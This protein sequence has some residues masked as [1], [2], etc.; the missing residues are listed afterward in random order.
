METRH[1]AD[2]SVTGWGRLAVLVVQKHRIFPRQGEG[3]GAFLHDV[4][5]R[6][7]G[8]AN[9]LMAVRTVSVEDFLTV[10]R[11]VQ[12][13]GEPTYHLIGSLETLLNA[14]GSSGLIHFLR[15]KRDEWVLASPI[16]RPSFLSVTHKRVGAELLFA[17]AG[18]PNGRNPSNRPPKAHT[19]DRLWRAAPG[20][21][22]NERLV[23][24]NLHDIKKWID[25]LLDLPSDRDS[26]IPQ[27][28]Y[29]G[30]WSEGDRPT[31]DSGKI[32]AF[33]RRFDG[34][35]I[36]IIH[37]PESD[38]GIFIHPLQRRDGSWDLYFRPLNHFKK[39]YQARDQRYE[40]DFL[41][42]DENRF[43]SWALERILDDDLIM[44]GLVMP[45]RVNH[46]GCPDITQEEWARM[47]RDPTFRIEHRRV[48]DEYVKRGAYEERAA[49][50]PVLQD[51]LRLADGPRSV[52]VPVR[53]IFDR[54][55]E[56]F[57]SHLV[58]LMRLS[59]RCLQAPIPPSLK[60]ALTEVL[61]G[62][63][64]GVET[65]GDGSITLIPPETIPIFGDWEMRRLAGI[66]AEL[67]DVVEEPD[68]DE[69]FQGQGACFSL[70][71]VS[72]DAALLRKAGGEEALPYT[73]SL[74]RRDDR[75]DQGGRFRQGWLDS[76]SHA[77][78][79]PATQALVATLPNGDIVGGLL[80]RIFQDQKTG[81]LSLYYIPSLSHPLN[82]W[83]SEDFLGPAL[84]DWAREIAARLEMPLIEKDY[85]ITTNDWWIHPPDFPVS[86]PAGAE[87]AIARLE[88]AHRH[89]LHDLLPPGEGSYEAL[90][91]REGGRVLPSP[92]VPGLPMDLERV[93]SSKIDTYPEAKKFD[94]YLW[95]YSTKTGRSVDLFL[96]E[97][98][99]RSPDGTCWYHVNGVGVGKTFEARHGAEERDGL[100]PLDGSLRRFYMTNLMHT[101]AGPLG[102]RT[103]L[104]V[105]VFD[106]DEARI[107]HEK[108]PGMPQVQGTVFELRREQLRLWDLEKFPE[109]M[110]VILEYV[111]RKVAREL[112][113]DSMSVEDYVTWLA[114]EI[115]R[116]F[117][118]ME[119][120]GFD[121]GVYEGSHQL[122]SGNVSLMAEFFDFDVAR[123]SPEA[124]ERYRDNGGIYGSDVDRG[125]IRRMQERWREGNKRG[126][127]LSLLLSAAPRVDFFRE[128]QA[129]W[130]QKTDELYVRGMK[131]LDIR[132]EIRRFNETLWNPLMKTRRWN[133]GL[134][135]IPIPRVIVKF[136]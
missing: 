109:R 113:K 27:V 6:L 14:A 115:G 37:I 55:Q 71:R 26:P 131:G 123:F 64:L 63:G 107:E 79:D 72:K 132:K 110:P 100:A 136:Y 124:S 82:H 58:P 49:R 87:A 89:P 42:K 78:W 23:L 60:E 70:I 59:S 99:Y 8:I 133:I 129:A 68:E 134:R 105:S 66:L 67:E 77:Y 44:S 128:M 19:P 4:A 91:P 30:A 16:A 104:G 75:F 117:A 120:F 73:L 43:F 74:W 122:H 48:S 21:T 35:P 17:Q 76:D 106:R 61:K 80:L 54:M 36:G 52:A 11:F 126:D 10:H 32:A 12:D 62:I 34:R 92:W 95:G 111:I 112:A 39:D 56:S 116:Q 121:H 108:A 13:G 50:Y 65:S 3:D 51:W 97:E 96:G 103:S 41:K 83:Y 135:S 86:A 18:L 5:S 90:G 1:L 38:R 46:N 33:P 25:S 93:T 119:F 40:W 102:F 31:V 84:L 22:G 130:G 101:I 57:G 29:S 15:H 125:Q 88:G 2:R 7:M 94:S 81:K 24:N 85:D 9:R 118:I 53:Q 20:T 114:R 28:A 69:F 45:R 47:R 127:W 98:G